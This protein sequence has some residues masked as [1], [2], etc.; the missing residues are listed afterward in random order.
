MTVLLVAVAGAVGAPA[1]YVIDAWIDRRV[2]G[3]FPWGI[4]VVNA[5]GC[6]VLGALVGLH[7]AGRL[8][9]TP[10]TV[11][12]TGLCGAFTTFSTHALESVELAEDGAWRPAVA[13]VVLMLAVCS[14]LAATGLA[15]ASLS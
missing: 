11:L 13:N 1:R 3:R 2:D 5:V 15:L 4:L 9:G 7:R 10:L 12:G 8:D 14:A 6:L